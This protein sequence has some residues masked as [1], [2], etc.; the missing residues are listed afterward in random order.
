[1]AVD[2]WMPMRA[3]CL[4]VVDAYKNWM[5]TGNGRF[6]PTGILCLWSPDADRHWMP[7]GV[8]YLQ[9]LDA[10]KAAHASRR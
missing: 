4:Q 9:A 5:P 2:D 6:T 10:R 1:M 7:L 8:G 3:R